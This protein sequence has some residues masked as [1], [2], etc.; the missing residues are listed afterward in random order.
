M[1]DISRPA[2]EKLAQLCE[3]AGG[4]W[5]SDGQIDEIADALL[6]LRTALD[7]AQER[8]DKAREEID[9]LVK[10]MD[11]AD[12]PLDEETHKQVGYD[13]PDDAEI[14][15]TAGTRTKINTLFLAISMLRNRA[16]K[17]EKA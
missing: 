12:G 10:L 6:E 4:G 2:I 1:T 11:E 15:I 7:T 16:L 14:W 8:A 5:W 3:D 9:Y 17:G 13:I